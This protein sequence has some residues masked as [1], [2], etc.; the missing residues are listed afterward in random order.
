MR[1]LFKTITVH[2]Q[3][4]LIAT[5]QVVSLIGKQNPLLLTYSPLLAHSRHTQP[6]QN[7]NQASLLH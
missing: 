3:T 5:F 1:R 7:K 6:K 4:K 2:K